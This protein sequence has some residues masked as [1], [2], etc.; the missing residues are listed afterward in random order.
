MRT[1]CLAR[2]LLA[3][4]GLAH[5][6]AAQPELGAANVSAQG[7]GTTYVVT[8]IAHGAPIR[9]SNG[10]AFGPDGNLYIASMMG[11]EIVG[12]GAVLERLND[13]LGI[14]AAIDDLTFGPDGSPYWNEL[15]Q[16]VVGRRAPD[17]TVHRQF[18]GV[19]NNPIGFSPAGRL[20]VALVSFGDGFYE[21][22]PELVRDPRPI[23]VATEAI[24]YPIG[25]LNAF[26]VLALDTATGTRTVL[27]TLSPGLDNIAFDPAGELF[28]SNYVDGSIVHVRQDGSV[29]AV[30]P[31]GMIAPQGVAVRARPDGS[32]SLYIGDMYS[33]RELD[34]LDGRE[35]GMVPGILIG[36][37]VTPAL[38]VQTD[39]DHLVLSSWLT[40][41]VQ[42]WDP[43]GRTVLEHHAFGAP[44]DALHVGDDL[45]VADPRQGGVVW[46]STREPIL[47][48]D[49]QQ[50]WLPVGL[51]TDGERLW[52]GDWATGIVWQI[53]FDGRTP[54]TPVPIAL[55]LAQPE[56]LAFDGTGLL[57]VETGA[58][59]LSR[60][61]LATGEARVLVEGLEIW[62]AGTQ[63]M[64]LRFF[65][66]VAVGPSGTIYVTGDVTNVVYRIERR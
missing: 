30:L 62:V 38:T 21:L 63:S 47:A 31:G 34:G 36:Q 40:G 65:T 56:G 16:G 29:R 64:P 66:G 33:L 8:E 10:M 59:R 28:V 61:D 11:M 1:A 42:V 41:A 6:A 49:R 51:A 58:G 23:I 57:V 13:D 60:I 5:V 53:G 15:A 37:G 43:D 19:G 3:G 20:F 35:L 9:G 32:A 45:V 25:F 24:P 18:V 17:G 2:L 27:A 4:L 48:I 54:T 46:A 26:E 39:G 55:D 12:S 52:V 14:F 7:Q 44:L 50:V 22:D